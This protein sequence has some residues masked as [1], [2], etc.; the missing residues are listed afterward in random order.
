MRLA[1]P[2]TPLGEHIAAALPGGHV[3]FTT[4]RG[5]VSRGPFATL[6]LGR[7]TDDDPAA[8]SR[9]RDLL[10]ELAGIPRERVAQGFQVHG[11]AVR[12]V[13]GPPYT[14]SPPGEA[15]GQATALLGVAA[16][17]LVADCLPIALIAPGAIAM[18]HAGW[19][20]LAGGVIE[21]GVSA[22]RELAGDVPIAAAIGPGAGPCCY[23]AGPEVHA[24]LPG[25]S[26]GRNVDL[27]AAAR[28]QLEEAGVAAVHDVGLCTICAD[29]TLFFSHRRDGGVTGR[30]AGLA[31]RT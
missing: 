16:L 29:P 18:V 11:A 26:R 20:G 5:G 31:W 28:R 13:E 25:C 3:L 21:Q 10:A 12:R 7:F 19:R 15:D 14:T 2:F 27:P 8:V 1:D 30:Q 22:V 17:V 24:A 23:E 4:R 9:N 6:N